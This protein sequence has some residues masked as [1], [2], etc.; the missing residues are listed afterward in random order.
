MGCP[1]PD[2]LHQAGDNWAEQAWDKH[3][4]DD[5]GE[6]VAALGGAHA[7]AATPADTLN[8][9]DRDRLPWLDNAGDEEDYYAVDHRRV[10]AAVVGGILL[11]AVVVGG[12]FAFTHRK[13]G[14]APVADGGL[15]G[16]SD[17][18]YKQ[19]PANPGGKQF[20]GTTIPASPRRRARIIPPS[21][22]PRWRAQA[23][24]ADR[25]AQG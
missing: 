23:R 25:S 19:A 4:W 24:R 7:G 5:H 6:A 2:Q 14:A 16:A 12:V 10:I 21:S 3:N 17:Q 8:L 13:D 20:E 18:P 11:L 1:D 9:Q 22:P 15:I